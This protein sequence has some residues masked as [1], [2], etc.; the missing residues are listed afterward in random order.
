MKVRW[1][2]ACFRLVLLMASVAIGW[3][4]VDTGTIQGTVTDAS[5][6]VVPNVRVSIINEGTQVRQTSE[7]RSDGTYVFTPVRIGVYTIEAE[8]QGF[9]KARSTGVELNIQQQAVVNFSLTPGEL[10]QTI[11]VEASAPLLQT[12][13]GSVGEVVSSREINN[14]PLS[15]RNYNF[16]ARLT[17]GVTHSQPEGRGLAAT[18]W[19]AANGTRP[20]QNNF[21]LDGIDNNSNNVD[22]L[23]GAAYVLKPPVDAV[24]EFKLQTNAFS[25]E[26]GRAGG[27]VLNASLKSGTNAF[28]GSLWEF[29]R[30]DAFDAADFFQHYAGGGKGAYRQNQF[31]GTLGGPIIRNKT[32]FFVDYEGTRIRQA[33]AWSGQTV[34]T[35][36][37]ARATLPTSQT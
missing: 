26:F 12:Q 21:L 7:T 17:A 33:A 8:F 1:E 3:A 20:A 25:A 28:H 5:G 31:G 13:N 4:Q 23:S 19:F 32:F 11:E 27:A 10:T 30:N 9:Q 16:L 36:P 34:P 15:G 18:G 6:G 24:G 22:F 14:L 2:V 29:L 35:L 37:S